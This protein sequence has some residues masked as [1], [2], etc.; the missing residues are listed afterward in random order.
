MYVLVIDDD[1]S[2]AE[3]IRRVLTN[4]GHRCALATSTDEA[5]QIL[6]CGGV[7]AQT[8]DLTMP[9]RDGLDWLEIVAGRD[10]VLARRTLVVTGNVVDRDDLNRIRRCGAGYLAKPFRL[11]TLV[12][13]LRQQVRERE[14]SLPSP[15]D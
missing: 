12:E 4:E 3:V 2:V 7:D 14:S 13:A 11:E 6:A 1:I 9:G 8:L 5:D 10:P 15:V